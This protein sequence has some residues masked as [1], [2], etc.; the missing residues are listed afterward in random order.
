MIITIPA[1]FIK[2][3][4]QI[5]HLK[6]L[7]FP[8]TGYVLKTAYFVESLFHIKIPYV[9]ITHRNKALILASTL[10]GGVDRCQLLKS[11]SSLHLLQSINQ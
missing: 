9:I 8:L 4:Y 3:I 5:Y 2:S 10:Q 7:S 11:R 6:V 1:R